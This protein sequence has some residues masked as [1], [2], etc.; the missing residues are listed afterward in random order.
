MTIYTVFVVHE[1]FEKWLT[2]RAIPFFAEVRYPVSVRGLKA[3]SIS[4]ST[5]L[6]RANF[7]VTTRAFNTET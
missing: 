2:H 4:E 5:F 1:S 6:G 3:C 7:E